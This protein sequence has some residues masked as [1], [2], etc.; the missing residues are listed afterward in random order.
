MSVEFPKPPPK[1]TRFNQVAPPAGGL[2]PAADPGRGPSDAVS[3]PLNGTFSAQPSGGTAAAN[4]TPTL[5][6][7][8]ERDRLIIV[9]ATGQTIPQGRL[10]AWQLRSGTKGQSVLPMTLAPGGGGVLT[11]LPPAEWRDKA[12]CHARVVRARTPLSQ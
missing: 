11:G 6:C 9:N 3:G 1:P 7:T 8:Q 4:T 10:I 12:R 5:E 2:P